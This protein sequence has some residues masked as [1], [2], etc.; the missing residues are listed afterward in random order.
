[1]ATLQRGGLVGLAKTVPKLKALTHL[2]IVVDGG[3]GY[4][5]Y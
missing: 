5:G 4:D 3:H 2:A 1:M